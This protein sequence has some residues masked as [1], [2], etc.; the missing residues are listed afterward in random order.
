[1]KILALIGPTAVGKTAFSFALA[2]NLN[3]EII[4]VDSR[5]VYRYMDV[6][7]D[8]A[9]LA[10]R[11]RV[12]HHLID[13]VDPDQIFDSADFVRLTRE[14]IDRAVV[15]GKHLLLVGGTAFYYKALIDGALSAPVG[16]D[17]AYR[18]TLESVDNLV[19]HQM[20]ATVDPVRAQQLPSGD[21]YR[22]I[23][24]LEICH[25]TGQRASDFANRQSQE[26]AYQVGYIGL[27]RDRQVLRNRIAQRVKEQFENGYPEEVAWLLRQGFSPDLPSMKGFGY[28][29]LVA[30]HQGLMTYEQ[31]LE[32]DRVA[33]CQFAKRQMT[34]F[35][36]FDAQWF[37]LDQISAVQAQ[38]AIL[39]KGRQFL[40]G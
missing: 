8:K 27:I 35:R 11:Q 10:D 34:W 23:R 18:Q 26:S 6:G 17:L 39:D 24:A 25:L 38:K 1:M 14:A 37:D 4:S 9:S 19:L 12:I 28:R 32:G 15:R 31:A 22:V 29:E 20:L 30:M 3:C 40:E 21:R 36:K 5:Q 33:T 16:K 2:E 7:T 13:V